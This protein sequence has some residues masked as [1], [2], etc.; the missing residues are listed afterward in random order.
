M[1]SRRCALLCLLSILALYSAQRLPSADDVPLTFQPSE[2]KDV[3]AQLETDSELGDAGASESDEPETPEEPP[4]EITMPDGEKIELSSAA[5][6][7]HED[8][9]A[10]HDGAATKPDLP[11]A[12]D[13]TAAADTTADASAVSAEPVAAATTEESTSTT[14]QPAARTPPQRRG[15]SGRKGSRK[16]N[17]RCRV[18][19]CLRCSTSDRTQCA[20]CRRGFALTE[21]NG[22]AKCSA[23]CSACSSP[24]TCD[25]CMPGFTNILG[26][27]K[28]CAAHCLKCDAAGEG[29]CNEC[30]ARRMLHVR[31]ELHGEVHEC[32]PCGDGCRS[33]NE[34]EG[35][36]DCENSF[37]TRL[38]NGTGCRLSWFRVLTVVG[39]IVA[40]VG[41]LC[42]CLAA[43]DF[44]DPYAARHH[45]E[46]RA[47]TLRE[48]DAA[49]VVGKRPFGSS[50]GS[51]AAAGMRSRRERNSPPRETTRQSSGNAYSQHLLPG[52]SG[53]EIVDAQ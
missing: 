24:E 26:Q 33:C 4:I 39:I 2:T 18:P 47:Q 13:T 52:Y 16:A 9:L 19:G 7:A 53:I 11:V 51:G 46:R 15:G 1:S 43:E 3:P 14:A 17:K 36:T 40:I 22:C 23:G 21:A 8:A 10:H 38:D 41:G 45:A 50:A 35:C 44:E 42:L 29:G 37:Y 31:L 20:T 5:A 25:T 34:E 28:P 30:G 32:L 6:H 12:T 27:C 48:R 49:E